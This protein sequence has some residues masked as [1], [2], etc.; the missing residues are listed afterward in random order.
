VQQFRFKL[1]T[2]RQLMRQWQISSSGK[3]TKAKRQ[4]IGRGLVF[5]VLTW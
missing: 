4:K 2:Q 5:F 1:R 3:I